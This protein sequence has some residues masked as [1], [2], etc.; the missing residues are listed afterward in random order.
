MSQHGSREQKKLAKKKAKRNERRSV[1]PRR[2]DA[3]LEAA[4]RSAAEWPVLEALVPVNLWVEGMGALV[5]ARQMPD[6]RVAFANFLVDTY[7][8]GVKN[9]AYK[10]AS[11]IEYRAMKAELNRVGRQR[12]VAPEMFAKLIADAVEYARAIGFEPHPDFDPAQ[13]LLAGIDTSACTDR[14]EFGKVGKPFYV[15]GPHD[16]PAR[17][18]AIAAKVQAAGGHFAIVSG[19]MGTDLGLGLDDDLDDE[20][21]EE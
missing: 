8:L 16:S 7:C 12:P 18:S 5:I 11:P 20:A 10:I 21:I 13:L 15:Q 4:F 17:A 19:G 9:A 3:W 6:G 1:A 2:P 14:F